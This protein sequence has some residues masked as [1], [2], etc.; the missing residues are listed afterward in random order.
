MSNK[1][2]GLQ[3]LAVFALFALFAIVS[4]HLFIAAGLT[5]AGVASGLLGLLLPTILEKP[6]RG[7]IRFSSFLG[8]WLNPIVSA[9]L[10][11][12]LVTLFGAVRR[13]RTDSLGLKGGQSSTW[14]DREDGLLS[15]QN[16]HFQY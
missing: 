8:R 1:S 13:I 7:W 10:Y 11:F 2:F 3:F 12:S 6:K 9:S 14:V 4:G 16:I 15:S 5:F